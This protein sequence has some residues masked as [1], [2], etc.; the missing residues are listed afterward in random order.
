LREERHVCS[1]VGKKRGFWFR[2]GKKR[3]KIG[4]GG[5]KNGD[6]KEVAREGGRL[7]SKLISGKKDPIERGGGKSNKCPLQRERRKKIDR[8]RGVSRRGEK[9]RGGGGPQQR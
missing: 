6:G 8:G 7:F 3:K 9:G 4:G 5:R 1:S 2:V